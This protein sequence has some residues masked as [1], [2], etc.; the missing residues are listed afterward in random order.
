MEDEIMNMELKIARIRADTSQHKLSLET[1]I[2]Q[3]FISLFE[4]GYRQPT[5]RQAQLIAEALNTEP[6]AIFPSIIE[7]HIIDQKG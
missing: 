2:A 1:G 5:K 6:E 4:Q 3:T 7:N